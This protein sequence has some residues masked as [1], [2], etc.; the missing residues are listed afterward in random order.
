MGAPQISVVL[1]TYNRAALLA[2]TLP[3]LLA[4]HALSYEVVVADDGSTDDTPAVLQDLAARFAGLRPV[5]GPHLGQAAALNAGIEAAEGEVVVFLDDD[6][7]CPPSLL[8]T[9]A[10]A[11]ARRNGQAV[12]GPVTVA[13][14]SPRTLA[15][16]LVE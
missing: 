5:S 3:L 14:E 9:H 16:R 2:R 1:A 13:P 11:H 12:F 7:L 15:R 8:A 10:A 4:Q 6:I